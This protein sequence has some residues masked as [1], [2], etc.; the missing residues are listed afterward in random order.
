[1]PQFVP[2]VPVCPELEMVKCC[3]DAI[4]LNKKS[5]ATLMIFIF[6]NLL[7]LI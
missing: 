1:M 3:A 2:E 4:V 6:I 5:N 7:G